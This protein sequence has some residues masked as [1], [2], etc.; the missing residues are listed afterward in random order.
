VLNLHRL[1]YRQDDPVTYHEEILPTDTQR[2]LLTEAKNAIRDYLR[3]VISTASTQ[4]F[5]MA[6]KVEPR[7]RT[8]GSWSYRTCLQPAHQP[9]Q[10]MDW[11]FGVYLP[12]TIWQGTQPGF[13]AKAYFEV[14]ERALVV[15]CRQKGWHLVTGADCKDTCIRIQITT[16]CHID[17]PLYAAP[18]KQF[19]LISEIAKSMSASQAKRRLDNVVYLA[20]DAAAG[21]VPDFPWDQL[22]QIMLAT[23][24]GEWKAS[25][26]H[27][28]SRWYIDAVEEHGEQLRRVSRYLKG[29]RDHQWP[30][31]RGPSSIL[32]MVCATEGFEARWHR[33]DVAL[34]EAAGR[35]SS[36]L[37]LDVHVQ[38][39]DKGVENFNRLDAKERAIASQLA[40]NLRWSIELSRSYSAGM[41]Y[42][43]VQN[44]QGALGLRL[45]TRTDFVEIEGQS[46]QVRATPAITVIPPVVRQTKAG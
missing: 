37:L 36:Q 39:I 11:D 32:L 30:A 44:L 10:E 9:P 2:L 33:D 7:F 25:D 40:A 28:V 31:G 26:P 8:Q 42:Q 35:L 24:S 3:A 41:K 19:V 34:Q 46:D 16:W 20:E 23:R 17:L 22:G 6:R 18:E 15:L 45:P 21:E 27:A 29:W 4:V 12:A 14:V 43:A 13:A 5:G 1:L 38:G